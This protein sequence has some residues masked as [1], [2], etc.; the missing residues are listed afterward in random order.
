MMKRAGNNK[1]VWAKWWLRGYWGVLVAAALAFM[2]QVTGLWSLVGAA[3]EAA[4]NT[5][6]STTG[7][8]FQEYVCHALS[9]STNILISLAVLTVVIAGVIYATSMGSSS[10]ELSIGLAK[11]MIVAAL[12]GLLLYMIGVFL[13]GGCGAGTGFIVNQLGL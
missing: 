10:G 8:T 4:T 9:W 3:T 12:T 5:G 11:Q 6:A 13:L 7:I 2:L 1:Q